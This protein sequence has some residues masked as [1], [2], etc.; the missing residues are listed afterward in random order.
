MNGLRVMCMRWGEGK[1]NTKKLLYLSLPPL[2]LWG[3]SEGKERKSVFCDGGSTLPFPRM[4]RK[5]WGEG[6]RKKS[7]WCLAMTFS[8][9][10]PRSSRKQGG[11]GRKR[12]ESACCIVLAPCISRN[13]KSKG[14]LPLFVLVL[15]PHCHLSRLL[16][17]SLP[18]M[19]LHDYYSVVKL[20]GNCTVFVRKML[21]LLLAMIQWHLLLRVSQ[22]GWF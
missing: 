17:H 1:E 19:T 20:V 9:T 4:S 13:L 22:L 5:Q 14:Y 10:F 11:E 16:L 12:K 8:F 18:F 6:G 3:G 21:P 15:L 7:A 2:A